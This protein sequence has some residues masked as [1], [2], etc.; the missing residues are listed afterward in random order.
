MTVSIRVPRSRSLALVLVGAVLGVMLITPVAARFTGPGP[1]PKSE[2][3]QSAVTRTASANCPGYGFYPPESGVNY[4]SRHT[5]RYMS[6][7]VAG[8]NGHFRCDPRLPDGAVV[9]KVRFTVFDLTEFAEV[10]NCGLF[11]MGLRT[12]SVNLVRTLAW[13]P[14]TELAGMPDIVRLT[15]TSIDRPTIQNARFA[16]YLQCQLSGTGPDIGIF[17]ANVTY[18]MGSAS[19]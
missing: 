1:S 17:G 11:R 2:V 19:G 13:V 4:A 3:V 14:A 5:M 15:T 9:T 6:Q 18:R 7:D 10:K 16:Y 8:G 12:S